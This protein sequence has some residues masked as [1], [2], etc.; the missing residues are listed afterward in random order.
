MSCRSGHYV[1]V[2][3]L[4]CLALI[5]LDWLLI[6]LEKEY[7]MPQPESAKQLIVNKIMEQDDSI[8]DLFQKIGITDEDLDAFAEDHM[9]KS[10][11]VEELLELI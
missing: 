8:Y 1:I 9:I 10:M 2:S 5:V 6:E 4:F 3:I 11:S 7:G